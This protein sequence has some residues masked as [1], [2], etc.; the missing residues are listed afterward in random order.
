MIKKKILVLYETAGGGHYSAAKAIEAAVRIRYPDYTT[1]L[2]HISLESGSQRVQTMY[3]GYNLLLKL[4]PSY[5]RMGM[6]VLNT[7]NVEKVLFPLLPKA[8][9]NIE[10]AILREKPD[11][12]LSVFG[13][14]NYAFIDTLKTLGLFGKIPYVIFCTDLTRHFL[15]GWAHPE[16]DQIIVMHQEAKEQMF[17][18]GVPYDKIRVLNGIP[19]NPMF[20][21]DR[22]PALE[23]RKSLGLPA[24]PFLVLITMGGVAVRNTW[25]ISKEL[26]ESG[27]PI[28][29]VVCCGRN[30]ALK[31]KI[32]RIA[33]LS[34]IP[35]RVLGFTDQMPLLM[36]AADLVVTKPGPG[37]IAEATVKEVPLLID[38]TRPPMPQEKGNLLYALASGIG[39][40]I[41]HRHPASMLVQNLMSDHERYA[42]IKAAMGRLKNENAIFELVD[43]VL[44]QIPGAS[45]P[46]PWATPQIR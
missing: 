23:A 43:A 33:A 4:D 3:E 28:Q 9:R 15:R 14:I 46:A 35:V 44:D 21:M 22:K 36:D 45:S 19:V 5:T 6:S 37:T 17:E 41:D 11:I 7:V 30:K 25:R 34:P 12:I 40:A 16:A 20:W 18:Y 27:L 2:L 32:E 13:M 42:Q 24:E 38:A 26:M 31:K 39:L 29:L 1:S 10:R 8:A